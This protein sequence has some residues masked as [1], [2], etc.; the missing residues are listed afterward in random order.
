MARLSKSN[1]HDSVIAG[2]FGPIRNNNIT[3]TTTGETDAANKVFSLMIL[4]TL[5]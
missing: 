5:S 1:I 4:F 2:G 3:I